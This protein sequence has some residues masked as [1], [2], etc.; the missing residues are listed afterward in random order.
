MK[1]INEYKRRF[2]NLM[3]STLG[4]VKPLIAEQSGVNLNNLIGKTVVLKPKEFL[5]V[6]DKWFKDSFET[7]PLGRMDKFFYEYIQKNPIKGTII[8]PRGFMNN[9]V[10]FEVKPLDNIVFGG[11]PGSWSINLS[12][13]C[14]SNTFI[15]Y[16]HCKNDKSWFFEKTIEMEYT[17]VGLSD[18]LENRLPCGNYDFSKNDMGDN[19]TPNTFA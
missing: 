10:R 11:F 9:L 14:G 4:D 13:E 18:E 8:N 1:N 7:E 16:L 2:Y 19:E 12:Y 3:E 15:V 5:N 17:C 6:D